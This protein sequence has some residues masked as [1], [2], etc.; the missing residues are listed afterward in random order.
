M[1]LRSED[2]RVGVELKTT[3]WE[4]DRGVGTLVL[5]RPA[6]HN[7]W[8]G[9]MHMEMRHLLQRAE[10]D[11]GI[12]IVVITGDPDGRHFCPGA[13]TAA[14]EV[15]VARGAYDA[16]TTPDIATPG[17]GRRSEFDDDF[18]YFLGMETVVIAAVNGAAAGVGFALACWCDVRFIA[19]DAKLTTA[20]GRLNLPAEYGLSWILPRLIGRGRASD[21]LLSSRVF[22]GSEAAEMGLGTAVGADDVLHEAQQYAHGVV[23]TVSPHSLRATK[24]QLA[25]DSV[26][27][28]PAESVRDAQQ[29]LEQM[30]TEGDFREGTAALKERRDAEWRDQ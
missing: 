9:R 24:L 20:H 21:L 4:V 28:D 27:N 2:G 19:A 13:D 3:R 16:G 10:D 15:H 17:F 14:L 7:A 1:T 6:A 29:R 18:A 22:R 8:T 30:M 23:T 26:R 11:A 12:R 5:S 25:V